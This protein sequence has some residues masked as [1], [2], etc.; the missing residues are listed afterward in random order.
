MNC[1]LFSLSLP[2]ES[3]FHMLMGLIR[4][5]LAVSVI[6]AHSEPIFG[7]E[8]VGGRIAVQAFFMISGFYMAL[9]LSE[10][11][12]P[13]EEYWLFISNRIMKLYPTY[14][15]ILLSTFIFSCTSYILA[16]R[17]FNMGIW[18]NLPLMRVETALLLLFSNVSLLFQDILMFLGVDLESGSLFFAKDL[19]STPQESL[20]H[21]Y[22]LIPPAWS[23]SLELTFYLIAPKLVQ[24]KSYGLFLLLI[25]SIILRMFLYQHGF[26]N[27][28]WNYRFFPTELT[29]FILG[30]LAYRL[31][32]RIENGHLRRVICSKVVL[33]TIYSLAILFISFYPFLPGTEDLKFFVFIGY[34]FVSIPCIFILSKFWK[35]DRYIGEFSYPLYISHI[36]VLWYVMPT[37]GLED[38]TGLVCLLLTSLLAFVLNEYVLKRIE[39]YRQNRVL[40]ARNSASQK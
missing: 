38:N 39:N 2:S 4:F 8:L 34:L 30:I 9:I 33:W 29:F 10:K 1:F 7:L 5:L 21:P 32:K 24:R 15:I 16:G 17:P 13:I 19:I 40:Q 11:Y 3:T 28:P 22:L 25:L 23:V 31:Y 27:D 36:F 35:L 14:W 18:H 6:I 12:N 20:I 26:Q 37:L